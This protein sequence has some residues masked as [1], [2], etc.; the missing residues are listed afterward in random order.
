LINL[1]SDTYFYLFFWTLFTLTVNLLRSQALRETKELKWLDTNETRDKKT[2]NNDNNSSNKN[3]ICPFCKKLGHKT[4]IAKSCLFHNEWLD[5]N[6]AAILNPS[7]PTIESES[8][9]VNESHFDTEISSTVISKDNPSSL[10]P[11]IH[12]ENITAANR[13]QNTEGIQ[14]IAEE[15]ALNTTGHHVSV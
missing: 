7:F 6:K 13:K 15:Q 8:V 11:Y 3:I 14:P 12:S 10:E 1:P 2:N 9:K 5:A 4:K